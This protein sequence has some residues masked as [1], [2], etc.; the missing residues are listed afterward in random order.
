MGVSRSAS[1]VVAYTMAITRLEVDKA[2]RFVKS[3]RSYVWPNPGFMRQL[4]E[5]EEVSKIELLLLFKS[6]SALSAIDL[7]PIRSLFS[8]KTPSTLA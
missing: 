6:F 5:F 2:L 3:Q 1:V 7:T 4:K 8:K